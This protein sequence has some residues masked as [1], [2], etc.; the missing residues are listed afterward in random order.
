LV[1]TRGD[2]ALEEKRA[3][4]AADWLVRVNTPAWLRLAGLTTHA[5]ALSALPEI[6]SFKQVPSIRGP[7]ET[8]RKDAAAAWDAA[9]VAAWVAAMAAARAAARDA[10]WDAV[11]AKLSVTVSEL[12]NSALE[13]VERMIAVTK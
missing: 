4:M 3:L 6:T 8:A 1:N 12:Q 9:W 11:W 13:L 2:K 5:D 10:V 7:I